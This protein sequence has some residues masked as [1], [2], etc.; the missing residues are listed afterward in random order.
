MLS[1]VQQRMENYEIKM[2]SKDENVVEVST[3]IPE[4]V[5]DSDILAE[6][7]GGDGNDKTSDKDMTFVSIYHKDTFLLFRALCKLS[8]QKMLG[9]KK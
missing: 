3:I 2:S 1:V 6:V 5:A 9:C 4:N 8:Q 7:E